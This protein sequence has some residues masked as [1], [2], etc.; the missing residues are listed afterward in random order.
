MVPEDEEQYGFDVAGDIVVARMYFGPERFH[1]ELRIRRDETVVG[2]RWAADAGEPDEVNVA[3]F[4][5]G[6]VRSYVSVWP[7]AD[8]DLL[9]GWSVERYEYEGDLVSEIHEESDVTFLGE[10]ERES[11]VIRAS[12]DALGRVLE[13]RQ[14]GEGGEKVLYR[15]RGHGPSPEA[16][17]RHVEDR[18][19]ET[20][21]KVVGERAGEERIY[22]LV[23][24]YHEAWPL[25]PRIGLGRERERQQ[26][27]DSIDDAQELKWTVCN[28]AEFS[29]YRDGTVNWDLAASDPALARALAA[30][31]QETDD[32]DDAAERGR[33]MLNRTARRLQRL[34]WQA[35]A[36]VT[37]DFV[38]F[39]V[40]YELT[41]LDENLRRS[42]PAPLRKTLSRRGLI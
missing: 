30:I 5:D 32:P 40:D 33:T 1:E 12:Y 8:K 18:L 36:P 19:V 2:Y 10:R 41:H 13:L 11:N 20:I 17:Y 26:W 16:L 21:P 9:H 24:H 4:A 31:P 42:V 39:A 3:R 15:A 28:P 38:V 14:R 37:D 34:D 6:R 25:P 22:C 7:A 29:G 27:I 23:L 35:I